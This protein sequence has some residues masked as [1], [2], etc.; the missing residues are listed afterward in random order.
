MVNS[1]KAICVTGGAGFIGSA[2][3]TELNARDEENIFVVDTLEN[4]EKWKNLTGKRFTDL[5]SIENSF[6]FLKN[7]IQ[8]FSA[9]VHL[10]AC[11]STTETNA[12][13]LLENNYR[14]TINLAGLA[15]ENNKRFVYA[16]SAATY[17]DGSHGFSDDLPLLPQ[18][19]PLNMYGFSKHLVDLWALKHGHFSK[20][21]GLK[22]FN[23]FGP[24]E[25]H[26]GRMASAI[27]R[28]VP[29]AQRTGKIKLFASDDPQYQDGE[30]RRDF[31]YVKDCVAITA[32]LMQ[33]SACGLFNVGSGQASSWNRLAQAVFSSLQVPSSIEY[34][35]MPKDLHGKYQYHTQ[36]LIS[37]LQ[38]TL[39]RT[40]CRYSLEEAVKDYVQNHLLPGK[41][42]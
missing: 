16:S 12:E 14:Y 29:E 21:V 41:T 4:N 11:S 15:M 40:P 24:N 18:L 34:I 19:H 27:L 7:N 33:G 8:Q 30:Q 32:D 17:G 31:I 39:F 10:G 22:Y 2:L 35:P 20:I 13:Y 9:I 28:M 25:W 38:N 37:K 5:I 1:R 36:A 23:V 3:I 42:W 26:K 6:E